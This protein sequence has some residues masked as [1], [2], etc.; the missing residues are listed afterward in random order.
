[1]TDDLPEWIEDYEEDI[2]DKWNRRVWDDASVKKILSALKTA[3]KALEFYTD[4]D[5][6]SYESAD[7]W[8]RDVVI[9]EIAEKESRDP[10]N[11]TVIQDGG[12]TATEA[13]AKI[14]EGKF[15]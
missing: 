8:D 11:Y 9:R 6:Y 10:R 5:N 4:S 1:M 7:A 2:N 14:K 3:M 12:S 13:L 15:E